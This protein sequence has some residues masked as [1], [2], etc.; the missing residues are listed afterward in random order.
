M[1][2][3][4][5]PA[6]QDE[7]DRRVAGMMSDPNVL[8]GRALAAADGRRAVAVVRER[9]AEW[10]VTADRVGMIGFSA[11]AFLTADVALDPQGS[12]QLLFA[13]PI[14]GGGI[15]EG[16]AIPDDAPPF[17]S[18]IANDDRGLI[19]YLMGLYTAWSKARRPA[20]LHVF[21]RG[22]HGFGM[23]KQNGPVDRWIDLF[24]DW[25]TD[26]GFG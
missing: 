10:G 17:F 15:G 8:R 16:Q 14:Y 11:G 9:A 19:K 21:E 26:K 18:A 6:S 2:A 3:T 7:I 24:G 22:G 20:E 23:V 12:P 4:A 25:L 13:A 5:R 1:T